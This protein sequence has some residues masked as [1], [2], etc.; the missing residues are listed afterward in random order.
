MFPLLDPLH[1]LLDMRAAIDGGTPLA[2]QPI[3]ATA[4]PA[5]ILGPAEWFDFNDAVAMQ[6]RVCVPLVMV[7][8][9][10]RVSDEKIA[11]LA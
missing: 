7:R 10:I 5:H 3:A 9:A 1:P 8:A 6:T 4:P 11:A 2:Q